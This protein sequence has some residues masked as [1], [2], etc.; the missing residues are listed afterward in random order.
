MKKIVVFGS[1]G[2]MGRVI[3]K[4]FS[5]LGYHVVGVDVGV[6]SQDSPVHSYHNCDIND[7][8]LYLLDDVYSDT[9]IVAT[10]SALP[11]F[12]NARV[13]NYSFGWGVP[14]FDLGG[15]VGVS[16]FI[17][18]LAIENDTHCFTDLGLAPGWVNI[19][20]EN[21]Y[22][23][24]SKVDKVHTINM[25][26]GGLPYNDDYDYDDDDDDGGLIPPLNYELTWSVEGLLNEY[27]DDCEVLLNGEIV[28]VKGMSGLRQLNIHG[29][30][31]DLVFETFNTSGGASHTL[32]IMQKRGVVD[33]SY[34]TIRLPGHA[35]C[36]MMLLESL[37]DEEI[38]KV[39][40]NECRN[41]FKDAVVIVVNG[42]V[43][44]KSTHFDYIKC[45]LATEEETA[46]QRC[47][48]YPLVSVV[49]TTLQYGFPSKRRVMNYEDVDYDKFANL[50]SVLLE[51]D[52]L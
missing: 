3:C 7:N 43:C 44:T 35:S 1:E 2:Q 9:Q 46:M 18:D 45:I 4:G 8:K 17:H 32:P 22:K 29:L 26:V 14:Y 5:R 39:L 6:S 37:T 19:V 11:Y 34:Q 30:S 25:S 36:M 33:C 12:L 31:K 27:R 48:A 15:K 51:E 10:V 20:A 41:G 28:T 49:H 42:N 24:L 13:A 21:A 52:V 40:N 38:I 23:T 47:T 16:K 50:L